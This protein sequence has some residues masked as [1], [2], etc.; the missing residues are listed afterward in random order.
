[1]A[2]VGYRSTCTR[3]V[4]G[5]LTNA[6]LVGAIATKFSGSAASRPIVAVEGEMP[7]SYDRHVG[8]STATGH[9]RRPE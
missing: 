9:E 5:L 1:M 2:L 7:R 8:H 6:F 4:Q 3:A